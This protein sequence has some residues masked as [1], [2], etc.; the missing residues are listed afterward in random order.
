MFGF[1]KKLPSDPVDALIDQLCEGRLDNRF[2]CISYFRNISYN[3]NDSCITRDWTEII[4]TI[5]TILVDGVGRLADHFLIQKDGTPVFD[6]R[7]GTSWRCVISDE[8]LLTGPLF[9]IKDGTYHGPFSVLGSYIQSNSLAE[10]LRCTGYKFTLHDSSDIKYVAEMAAQMV[11]KIKRANRL[12]TD[13]PLIVRE[14]CYVDFKADRVLFQKVT[15]ERVDAICDALVASNGGAKPEFIDEYRK[16]II[17]ELA[18]TS[19]SSPAYAQMKIEYDWP[20][21]TV[22]VYPDFAAEQ[23]ESIK[24]K[25][26]ADEMRKARDAMNAKYTKVIDEISRCRTDLS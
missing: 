14:Y 26:A 2:R 9:D 12:L 8:T 11:N 24:A 23:A 13:S 3:M 7:Y 25:R 19:K 21:V 20:E 17:R 4:S 15:P 6:S 18:L 1:F 22:P 5:G 16:Y 10:Q